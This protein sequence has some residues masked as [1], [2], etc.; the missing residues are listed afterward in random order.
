LQPLSNIVHS[1][2]Y[3]AVLVVDARMFSILQIDTRIG[4][5]PLQIIIMADR[6]MEESV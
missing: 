3:E 2:K 4:R 5:L 1:A 6:P